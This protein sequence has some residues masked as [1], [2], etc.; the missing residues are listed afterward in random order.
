MQNRAISS[1]SVLYAVT[2]MAAAASLICIAIAT[3]DIQ[4]SLTRSTEVPPTEASASAL[5]TSEIQCEPATTHQA[6]TLLGTVFPNMEIIEAKPAFTGGGEA[7]LLEVELYADRA[8][9][10]THGI[11]YVL[12]GG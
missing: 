8:Y 9:P 11:V 6:A 12:P 7:C 3:L 4:S 5:A 1:L 2:S 10:S